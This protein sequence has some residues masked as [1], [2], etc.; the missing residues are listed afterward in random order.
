LYETDNLCKFNRIF[1]NRDLFMGI[2]VLVNGAAG[3]MGQLAVK[4]ISSDP[5]FILVG[6]TGRSD[7]LGAQIQ[8]SAADVVLDLTNAHV[9]LANLETIINAGARPVIG[10]SGLLKEQVLRM[11]SRCKELKLGGIIASNF[12]LGA[13]LM[14]KHAQEMARYF[15]H[16]EIIEMHHDGKLDSPSG[17]AVRTAEMLSSE[18]SLSNDAHKKHTTETLKGARGAVYEDI[19]IHSI[20][21]PGL[22]AHQQIIF[23]GLGETLTIRHDSIDRQC[24]MPGVTL[25]CKKVMGLDSLVYGLECV[26]E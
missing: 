22:V 18:R 6:E 10:T 23:G 14:M 15:P 3:K 24:F 25:A 2:R 20:R 5:E 26:L 21:L 19:H 1:N 12:S 16:V 11:Q 4:T 17:T 7:D 9:A 8:K 13:V